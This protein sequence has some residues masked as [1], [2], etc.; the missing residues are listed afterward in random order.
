MKQ[1][2]QNFRTGEL[3]VDEIP[4]PALRRGGVLV[5]TAFSLISAG[6]ER[7]TVRTGQSSLVGR[8][9][10]RP[11]LVRQGIESLKKEG[12]RSTYD[13][14]KSR[15]NQVKA[16]GYSSSGVVIAVG[17]Q[18][19][20]FRVGQPVACAG[21]TY[22]SH[23][24]VNFVPRNLCAGIPDGVALQDA[25]YATVGA[26]ALH[27]VRQAEAELGAGAVVIGLGL[28]GQLTVQLLKASGCR[29]L[30][31]DV[32]ENAREL[33]RQSGADAVCSPQQAVHECRRL[34]AGRGADSVLITAGTKSNEPIELAAD[35]ARDRA[36]VVAVGLVGLDVPRDKFYRKELELRLSRS[37]GPGRYDPAYEEQ[38]NDYPVG[39]VR[40][41]EK[42]NLEAFLGLLAAGKVDVSLLTTHRY[43]IDDALDAYRLIL[44]EPSEGFRCGVLI[45]YPE[46]G[47]GRQSI[48]GRAIVE[49][50]RKG[51]L[52]VSFIG[53]GN[54]AR[55][56][57][58][59]LLRAA[60]K[61]RL[62][63]V[64]T[65]TGISANNT[66]NQFG[67]A[68]ATTDYEE[69]LEDPA[70]DCVV[71]ATRHGLH[72]ELAAAAMRHGKAV[73]VEKPLA[74]N[75]PSLREVM[76]AASQT[77][78]LL[79]VGYNRRFAPLA[80]E[81]KSRMAHRAGALTISYRVNAG[82]VPEDHWQLDEGEGGGRILG[83]VCHFVDFVQYLTDS[84]P[85]SVCAASVATSP[86]YCETDD[87]ASI[88]MAMNDGS[89][90]SILYAS[91]GD[92]S[93]PKERIEVFCDGMIVTMEDFKSGDIV[94]S[95]RRTKLRGGARDKG[96]AAELEAFI[97]AVRTGSEPPISLQSLA[98]TSLATLA[99]IESLRAGTSVG[100]DLGRLA[101]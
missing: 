11:D 14:V 54:F 16:L 12:L 4:S 66:A 26:I 25:C 65:A 2:V 63:G 48:A 17:E 70:T 78:S 29:V 3:K 85:R 13:K 9:L 60:D 56:V 38:G 10:Q 57:L 88:S 52:G 91:S 100:V 21:A 32:A 68:Y 36:K 33:A 98:A 34:T 53:A 7:T 73:F 8:I 27:G 47:I 92:A 51:E 39:Y 49:R 99:V 61:V 79:M 23:A 96:H 28:L 77:G 72:A 50:P 89:L 42:R 83:E 95:G 20:E 35:L 75:Q 31:V 90:A 93:V 69:I 74:L 55:G 84:S 24:E 94:R 58:I 37:Y 15:L 67:F 64:A 19:D 45:E 80:G 22:A 81:L 41:T 46:T 59:P 18:A 62:V 101:E 86:A 40:W 82:R 5:R 76:L 44:D 1:V 97:S 71:I 30:G 43:G 6:T 87:S